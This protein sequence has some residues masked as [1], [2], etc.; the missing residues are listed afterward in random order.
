MTR[1]LL[2]AS[3]LAISIVLIPGA[4]AED[5]DTE[6]VNACKK[7]AGFAA[8]SLVKKVKDN[9]E[10]YDAVTLGDVHGRKDK[11]LIINGSVDVYTDINIFEFSYTCEYNPHDPAGPSSKIVEIKPN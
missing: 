10:P 4:S 6:A 8:E 2:A 1:L 5:Q 9:G 11:F 3:A 7:N